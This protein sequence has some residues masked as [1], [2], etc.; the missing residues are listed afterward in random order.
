MVALREK[1]T[2]WLFVLKSCVPASDHH[3]HNARSAAPLLCSSI[4]ALCSA[5]GA[6]NVAVGRAGNRGLPQVSQS[7]AWGS[8]AEQERPYCTLWCM[9]ACSQQGCP[10][11]TLHLA[12]QQGHP[13]CTLHAGGAVLK[14]LAWHCPL[15]QAWGEHQEPQRHRMK[16]RQSRDGLPP[17]WG[18]HPHCSPAHQHGKCHPSGSTSP[19]KSNFPLLKRF[20]SACNNNSKTLQLQYFKP[21]N[22]CRSEEGGL[23]QPFPCLRRGRVLQ[24][25]EVCQTRADPPGFALLP[26]LCTARLR[27]PLCL[28][29]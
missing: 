5:P 9:H 14:P 10:R 1:L 2:A 19:L 11:C 18:P 16:Q 25:G 29:F 23:E 26:A 3:G 21:N 8:A 7:L 24:P 13:H 4:S 22:L 27:P 17:V 6:G 28:A 12:A 15:C 20:P